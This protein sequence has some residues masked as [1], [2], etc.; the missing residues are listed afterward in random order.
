MSDLHSKAQRVPR[1]YVQLDGGGLIGTDTD[2]PEGTRGL[3]VGTE[4][5]LSAVMSG[6]S[7]DLMPVKAGT[8]MGEFKQVL[9]SGTSAQD[10]WAIV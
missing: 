5:T 1:L 10:I 3:L 7:V 9:T 8:I 6:G 4:G 2:C